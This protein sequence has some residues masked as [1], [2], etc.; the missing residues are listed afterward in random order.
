MSN[1]LIISDKFVKPVTPKEIRMIIVETINPEFL[2]IY[3]NFVSRRMIKAI[4]L[5][6]Q[7][8]KC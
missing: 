2:I 7:K 3:G 1:A 8:S 4:L 5:Y 6:Q